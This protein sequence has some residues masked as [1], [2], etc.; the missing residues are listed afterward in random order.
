MALNVQKEHLDPNSYVPLEDRTTW[1]WFQRQERDTEHRTE[2]CVIH[3]LEACQQ[4]G[5]QEKHY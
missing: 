2:V 5:T 1:G 3:K 4:T